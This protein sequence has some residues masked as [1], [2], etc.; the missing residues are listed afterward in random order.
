MADDKC[1]LRGFKMLSQLE[2]II[3]ALESAHAI[4]WILD[5]PETLGDIAIINV[6]GR[7]DKDLATVMDHE[8]I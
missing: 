6:S 1:A 5:N 7:G 3:P 4:G 8:N 2:G